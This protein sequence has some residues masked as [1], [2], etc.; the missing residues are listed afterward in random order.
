MH[1]TRLLVRRGYL[2]ALS[3]DSFFLLRKSKCYFLCHYSLSVNFINDS[4]SN[5]YA[6][7]N[8]SGKLSKPFANGLLKNKV[9]FV[10]FK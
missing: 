2:L 10:P 1:G 7:I 9:G 4:I 8:S 3:F 6:F 5:P